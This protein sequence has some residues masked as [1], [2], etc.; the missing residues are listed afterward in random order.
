M[1]VSPA[2]ISGLV[3][4]M[5]YAAMWVGYRQ[6]WSWLHSLDWSLLNAAHNVAEKHP[7]WVPFWVVVSFVL[8]PVPLRLLGVVAVIIA[9]VKRNVRAAVLLTLCLLLTGLVTTAAKSLA[10]RH[11]PVTALVSEPSS[12]FPSGHALEVTAGTLALLSVLWP[13]LNGTMR[14]VA[15][16][17]VVLD[18]VSVGIAWVAVNVHRPSDVIAGWALG[19]GFFL[20][21]S[22]WPRGSRRGDP[23]GSQ[24]LLDPNAERA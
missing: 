13:V 8:G 19:Y 17:I 1:I 11:R 23:N 15:I 24:P 9:A 16:A 12:S 2:A 3:A 14:R 4:V 21:A 22:C 5:V 10:H 18:V 6:K 7:A 20:L